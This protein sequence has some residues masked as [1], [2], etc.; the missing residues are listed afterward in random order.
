MVSSLTPSGL[1]V[2][3]GAVHKDKYGNTISVQVSIDPP[4][5]PTCYK[6]HCL[7]KYFWSVVIYLLALK[8]HEL[9]TKYAE[10]NRAAIIQTMYRTGSPSPHTFWHLVWEIVKLSFL[11]N[12]SRIRR[13]IKWLKPKS[14][15]SS[16]T[17]KSD[18]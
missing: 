17:V 5:L 2:K 14:L 1:S 8:Y 3:W 12:K 16:D 15:P 6:L 9:R 18:G 11:L 13:K 7:F 4:K 10:K